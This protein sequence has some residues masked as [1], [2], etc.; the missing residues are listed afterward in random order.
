MMD[1]ER[2]ED[3]QGLLE[4]IG[5]RDIAVGVIGLGYVGLP[6]AMGFVSA[7]Y[8]VCGFDV[9]SS[10][11][12]ALNQGQSYIADVDEVE[13]KRH[14]DAGTFTATADFRRLS[15]MDAISICV[16]TPLRKTK[17]PDISYVVNAV[18]QVAHTLRR[19]QIVVLESTTYPGTTEELVLPR[20]EATTLRVRQ[21]L[22]P[23][24]LTRAH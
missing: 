21:R 1:D 14:V 18:E 22:L 9:D 23:G 20:L 16:P 7:G 2:E 4:R 13:L 5:E 17:D 10:R 19:G 15:Q 12:E 6:L 3:T 11:V 24:L 8:R